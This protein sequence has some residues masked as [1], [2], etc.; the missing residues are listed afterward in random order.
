MAGLPE[1]LQKVSVSLAMG[2]VFQ[3]NPD[4]ADRSLDIPN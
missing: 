1:A 2:C 4:Y 3:G